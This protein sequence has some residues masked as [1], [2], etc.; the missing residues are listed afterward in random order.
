MAEGSGESAL[1]AGPQELGT[2]LQVGAA[3]K[4]DTKVLG[5]AARRCEAVVPSGGAHLPQMLAGADCITGLGG[6]PRRRGAGRCGGARA[7]KASSSRRHC[8]SCAFP[9]GNRPRMFLQEKNLELSVSFI[10]APPGT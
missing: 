3:G 10:R 8:A 1:G 9:S 7:S 4:G 2:V 6:T 5:A